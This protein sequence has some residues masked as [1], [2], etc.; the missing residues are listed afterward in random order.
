MSKAKDETNRL[1]E[2]VTTLEEEIRIL[3]ETQERKKWIHGHQTLLSTI[4][5][6]TL[7][8]FA[9]TIVYVVL[10]D[11]SPHTKFSGWFAFV[12]LF[13]I[14]WVP[15][16]AIFLPS[17]VYVRAPKFSVKSY[18]AYITT[19][20]FVETFLVFIDPLHLSL[21]TEMG[22]QSLLAFFSLFQL[23]PLFGLSAVVTMLARYVGYG[24]VLQGS[25]LCFEVESNYDDLRKKLEELDEDFNF[26]FDSFDNAVGSLN[27]RKENRRIQIFLKTAKNRKTHLV[28][29][30]HSTENDLPKSVGSDEIRRLVK[31]I[32]GWLEAEVNT[33]FT[34]VQDSPFLKQ[35]IND[36]EKI[37]VRRAAGIPS[38]KE[39]IL[40]SRNHWKD[41]A[42]VLST[43]AALVGILKA[44][45]P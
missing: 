10:W 5:G 13:I 23:I 30:L 39:I 33:Q 15:P 40:W 6:I 11:L 16:L 35:V 34:E 2:R 28:F 36:S 41:I 8:V 12:L 44:I 20:L 32:I 37:F 26:S 18:R 38:K 45:A 14:L 21:F 42:L 31:G 29:V 24:V 22:L 4:I 17:V 25:T 3:K 19:I 7:G 43:I 9:T 27:Y 1:R